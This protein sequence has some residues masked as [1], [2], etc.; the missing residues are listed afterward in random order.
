MHYI[1]LSCTST[2]VSVGV[3]GAPKL[4][5]CLSYIGRGDCISW[6]FS[7]A[8]TR[9]WGRTSMAVYHTQPPPACVV[10][11]CLAALPCA[12]WSLT[13]ACFHSH[14]PRCCSH[15][16]PLIPP[17]PHAEPT[18]WLRR[19]SL[20]AETACLGFDCQ[21]SQNMLPGSAGMRPEQTPPGG[22]GRTH[23]PPAPSVA[24]RACVQWRHGE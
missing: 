4:R 21:P 17:I 13:A 11:V 9:G 6:D 12:S 1:P 19:T 15:M 20:D 7:V 22:I 10:L 3:C 23:T 18:Q 5:S 24:M 16:P 2:C 8:S 14:A